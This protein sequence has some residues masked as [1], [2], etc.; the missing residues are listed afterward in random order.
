MF[1]EHATH[2][3]TPAYLQQTVERI[4]RSL[5]A[6]DFNQEDRSEVEANRAYFQER[7]DRLMAVAGHSIKAAELAA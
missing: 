6:T 7:H 1:S 5:E 3:Y 2:P 4:D